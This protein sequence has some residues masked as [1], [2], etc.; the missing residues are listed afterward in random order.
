MFG[1]AFVV[2][3]GGFGVSGLFAVGASFHP[4]ARFSFYT[5]PFE[6]F[7]FWKKLHVKVLS[8]G[9]AQGRTCLKQ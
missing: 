1:D 6:V 9:K 7:R 4:V 8:L 2:D 3:L 5:V